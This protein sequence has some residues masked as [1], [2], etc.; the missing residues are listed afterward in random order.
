[1]VPSVSFDED[2][3]LQPAGDGVW[4]GAI[5]ATWWT[6]R[7]PL[8]GYVMALVQRALA[9]AVDDPERLPRSTTIHFLRPPAAGPVT[10]G[11]TVDR[12]GR[13]LT[14]ASAR[15][16]QEGELLALALAAFS[17]P[18]PGP[19]LSE[20]SMPEVKPPGHREAPR[21]ALRNAK[22]P[23]FMDLLTMQHRFGEPAFS[24]AER[25]ET[26]GWLG[27]REER[28]LMARTA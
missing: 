25:A 9:L 12:A 13:S 4:E 17:K 10:V 3:A 14:S 20:A 24:G 8:G 2:T 6:P 11:A 26:G 7:G 18:W 19:T 22:R 5:S 28:P 15:L 23:P 27:L 1:M 16:E 21:G